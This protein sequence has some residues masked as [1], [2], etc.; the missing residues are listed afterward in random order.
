MAFVRQSRGVLQPN[1]NTYSLLRIALNLARG[2]AL[3]RIV[4]RAKILIAKAKAIFYRSFVAM[5]IINTGAFS[6][7]FLAEG[8]PLP[9]HHLPFFGSCRRPVPND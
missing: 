8:S 2:L 1:R 9:L 7:L 5:E 4:L 6:F 3:T